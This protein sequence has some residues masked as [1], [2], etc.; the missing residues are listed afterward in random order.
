MIPLAEEYIAL[1]GGF[2]ISIGEDFVELIWTTPL[3]KTQHAPLL[4]RGNRH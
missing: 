1:M 4:G 2:S 3:L